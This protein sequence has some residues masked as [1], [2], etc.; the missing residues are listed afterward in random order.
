MKLPVIIA[1]SFGLLGLADVPYPWVKKK[2]G[3]IGK[4]YSLEQEVVSGT[5][6]G[7]VVS[8]SRGDVITAGH[9]VIEGADHLFDN[10][11]ATLIKF[12]DVYALLRIAPMSR[13]TVELNFER[14]DPFTDVVVVGYAYGWTDPL[15]V[16][17]RVVTHASKAD[18]ANARW[19]FFCDNFVMDGPVVGG[20]SGGPVFTPDGKVVGL[21]QMGDYGL[22]TACGG[23][24]LKKFLKH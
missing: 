17:R 4:V 1:L 24:D 22:S 21:I 12:N 19:P 11:P 5:C 14:P 10:L 18:A 3:A 7:V 16:P 6:T 8:A 15:I 23:D 9:C 13:M 20:M 2:L